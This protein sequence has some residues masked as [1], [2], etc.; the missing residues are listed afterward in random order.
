MSLASSATAF[1]C[2]AL[3][4]A[5]LLYL[6]LAMVPAL[7]EEVPGA[8]VEPATP[9]QA[10][11]IAP[12]PVAPEPVAPKPVAPE[13]IA[14]E[15]IATPLAE[16][17]PPPRPAPPLAR[18]KARASR[19]WSMTVSFS[20][21]RDELTERAKAGLD[22]AAARLTADPSATARID[23][24]TDRVGDSAHNLELSQRRADRVADHLVSLGIDRARMTV[25]GLGERR[26]LEPDDGAEAHRRNR[27]VQ[28]RVVAAAADAPAPGPEEE[29]P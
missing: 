6:N 24:H 23:G 4:L 2:L 18:A 15:P 5:D 21:D 28:V 17:E 26:P 9:F 7:F 11:P 27:R 10:E 20:R 3:G 16:T 12:E 1:S 22:R 14:P 29:A 25:R 8:V 19:A 13:P